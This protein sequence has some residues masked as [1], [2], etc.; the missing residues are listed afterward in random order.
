MIVFLGNTGM[1]Y[2]WTRHNIGFCATNFY[3]K[4]YNLSWKVSS[5]FN[6]KLAES[7]Q[8]KEKVI[9]LRPGGF[10]NESGVFVQKVASF[11]KI[12]PQD[13]LVFCDDLNLDFGKIRFRKSGSDGGNNGLKSVTQTLGSRDF[14]RLRIGTDNEL[15]AKMGDTNFVLGKFSKDEKATLPQIYTKAGEIIN[16]FI[17]N[18]AEDS[19]FTVI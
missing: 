6:A 18:K 11:Y 8:G 17:A 7:K 3:A 4:S 1:Q 15:R 19:S 16:D 5:K 12:A 9:W 10:Y 13:I 2:R 14:A